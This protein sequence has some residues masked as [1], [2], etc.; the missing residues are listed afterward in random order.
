MGTSFLSRSRSGIFSVG[1][2]SAIAVAYRHARY[3][4]ALGLT[5][6]A[7]SVTPAAAGAGDLPSPTPFAKLL[8]ARAGQCV[9]FDEMAVNLAKAVAETGGRGLVLTAGLQ[10]DFADRWRREL[11]AA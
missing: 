6:V 10:Q 5:A 11:N 9:A 7:L 4:L 3:A 1:V 2:A 8:P